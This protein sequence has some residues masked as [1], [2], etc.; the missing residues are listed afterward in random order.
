MAAALP[1]A[2]TSPTSCAA[3]GGT[4]VLGLALGNGWFRGRLGW[5]GDRALYGAELGALA[6]LEITFADGHRQVVVTDETWRP[7]RPTCVANDLYDGQTIDA[8]LR[9]DAWLRPGSPA[10]GWIGVDAARTSTRRPLTPYVGP[11]VVRHEEVRPVRIWTSPSG[12][13]LVDF[14][15]N[16][17]GWL[18]FRVRGE[19]GRDDHHPARG[20]AG[21][22]RARRPAAAH[23]EGHRPVRPQSA[24]TTSSSPPS[25]STGSATPR[26]T[27]GPGA[28]RRRRSTR[29]SCTP[30]C[31]AP[32]DFECSDELLN[33][34]HR[35]VVWGLRGN[36]LDVPT[37]CPQ[38]D[39]RLG[40]TG[41]IAVFAPTAA[42][43]Y[44]VDGFLRDWLADLGRRAA[45]RGR[46]GALRGPGRAEVRPAPPRAPGRRRPPRSGATRRSGCRGRCGRPT[47]TATVLAQTSTTPWRR[48]SAGSSRCC[49]RAA[50]GTPASSSA[51]GSTR[52]RRRTS[53]SDAK[54]D[55]GVVATACLYRQ[56]AG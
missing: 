50:C 40:W 25:P 7:A 27:A 23:R 32:G 1:R 47:A 16:L 46:H 55:N 48:T 11:P 33:Q 38:R 45:G 21:G 4:V 42:F 22:R 41:D 28:H 56:R 10:E 3:P 44:D 6:Q 15:Q 39:E 30:T 36:F 24:A 52:R 13:T 31:A 19:R 14:G 51:T 37:D 35:N 26:S 34:L 43:L 18:R 17:V 54:A 29:S 49:R 8:R 2:T 12:R 20:G 9:D 5:S 53:P